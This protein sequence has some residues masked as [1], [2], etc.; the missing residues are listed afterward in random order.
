MISHI[1]D[2]RIVDELKE[3]D[4]VVLL[5]STP[6]IH[7]ESREPIIVPRGCTG[8]IVDDTIGEFALVEFADKHGCAFAIDAIPVKFLVRVLHEP[9]DV[10]V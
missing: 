2:E 7:F 1:V 5:Q 10:T 9:F 8:T 3:H 6:T 4:V